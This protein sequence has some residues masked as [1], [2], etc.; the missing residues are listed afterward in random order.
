M[1]MDEIIS[2][3]PKI[4][5]KNDELKIRTT[6][7]ANGNTLFA[8][9]DICRL[10]GVYN[11]T[12]NKEKLNKEDSYKVSENGKLAYVGVNNIIKLIYQN[13]ND[14]YN[15]LKDWIS[16]KIMPVLF[17]L[18]KIDIVTNSQN[19]APVETEEIDDDY[20]D[21]ES[22]RLLNKELKNQNLIFGKEILRV[23]QV[24]MDIQE[25]IDAAHEDMNRV[26]KELKN[27]GI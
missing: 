19:N 27:G 8:L 14:F 16:D 10:L 20:L 5:L 21:D 18:G 24:L 23:S 1:E 22:Y 4:V 7:D 11:S 12:S 17:Q 15:E 6:V 2:T 3:I 26:H 13:K 9:S 25:I